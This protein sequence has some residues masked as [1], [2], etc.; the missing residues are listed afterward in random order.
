MFPYVPLRIRIVSGTFVPSLE[1]A[2]TVRTSI[3]AK[4]VGAR[5]T[6]AV[7]PSAFWPGK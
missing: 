4:L 3:S 1:V 7:A 5:V 6:S 2:D